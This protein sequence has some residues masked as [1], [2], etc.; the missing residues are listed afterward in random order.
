MMTQLHRKW[1]PPA[2]FQPALLQHAKTGALLWSFFVIL[3]VLLLTF[4][5]YLSDYQFV[6]NRVELTGQASLHKHSVNFVSYNGITRAYSVNGNQVAAG[7]IFIRFPKWMSYIGLENY[8]KLITFRGNNEN[9]YHYME[10]PDSW[11]KENSDAVYGFL[12]RFRQTLS[13]LQL[14]YTESPYFSGSKRKIFVTHS[15]YIIQ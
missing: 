1:N 8:H 9:E 11:V 3:G 14:R 4:A 10:P 5:I 12:Y 13:F 2:P 6:S 7:G 15:G